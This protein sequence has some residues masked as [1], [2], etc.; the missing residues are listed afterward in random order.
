MCFFSTAMNTISQENNKEIE[1]TEIRG[2]CNKFQFQL[3]FF[4]FFFFHFATKRCSF[5]LCCMCELRLLSI[6]HETIIY[7]SSSC[8]VRVWMHGWYSF[9]VESVW[10]YVLDVYKYIFF[11]NFFCH[12]CSYFF[13]YSF[14]LRIG[15]I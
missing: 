3:L 10:V 7:V 8:F 2:W 5:I 4:L 11:F 9:I 13:F 6:N 1:I 12:C 15:N 14:I